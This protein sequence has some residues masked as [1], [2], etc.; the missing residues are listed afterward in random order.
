MRF[1]LTGISGFAGTHL[2]ALLLDRGHDVFGAARETTPALDDL[3]RRYGERFL[4]SAVEFCDVRDR[5]RLR[6]ALRRAAPDGVFHLAALAFVPQSFA[7]PRLTYEVNLLGTIELLAAVRDLMPRA[8]VVCVTSSEIYGSIDAA[9]DLPIVE[10]QPLRPLTPYSVAKAAADLAAFQFHRTHALDVVRA[11]PFNHTGPGQSPM[12]VCSEFARALAAVELGAAEP[13]L[14]VG[15]LDVERDFSDVRDVVRGYVDLFER[16]KAG[17]AYNIGSGVATRVA[18][19]LDELRRQ[20]RVAVEVETDPRKMRPSEMR[21][22]VG[23]IAKIREATGWQPE[24]P[25]RQ[26]L[27]D[28]LDY[29]RADFARRAA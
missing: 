12:F 25:L 9:D 5:E 21:R 6:S 11:R 1:F 15:D 17:E 24:I 23:S 29:W 19:I 27:A 3:H 4:A 2:A 7:E 10:T 18:S 20:A 28:L 8:R 26:T 14:R 22:L 16:G 13:R